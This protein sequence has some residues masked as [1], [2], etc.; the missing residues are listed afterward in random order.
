[1]SQLSQTRASAWHNQTRPHTAQGGR[2]A[3]NEGNVRR[4]GGIPASEHERVDYR[5]DVRLLRKE[6][7]SRSRESHEKRPMPNQKQRRDYSLPSKPE[8]HDQVAKKISDADLRQ[9]VDELEM[10]RPAG[11]GD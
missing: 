5:S 11:D 10:Q 6:G 2:G 3:G 9:H 1:E 8:L 7:V 4:I